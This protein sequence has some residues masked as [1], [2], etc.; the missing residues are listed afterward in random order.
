MRNIKLTLQ[1]D[2]TNYCGWQI[3]PN[4]TTIQ[5]LISQFLA[6]LE[7]QA[8]T[9]HGAGRTD[10]GVHAH[11]QVANFVTQRAISCIQLRR[12]INANLPPDIRVVDVEE[13]DAAFHARYS[14][15]CKTYQYQIALSE[16]VSPFEYRYLYHYPYALAIEPMQ[17][18]TQALLGTHDFAAFATATEVVTTTRTIKT[19]ELT[20]QGD[21]FRL[22]ITGDGF[23][24]YM[25]RTIVGTLIEI[26]RGRRNSGEIKEILQSRDRTRAGP[27]APACGLTLLN[28]EY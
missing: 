15:R 16:I 1:Y 10:A 2:G 13:V 19:V 26:G 8:I 27:T 24:R 3:Q 12:A 7:G 21:R 6:R 18:A 17:I 22:N 5:G 14:A 20:Q 11:G 4:G 25:V 28:V 9:L 23:L